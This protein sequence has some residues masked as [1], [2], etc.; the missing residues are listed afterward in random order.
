MPHL[1]I[2]GNTGSGKSVFINDLLI[3]LLL[4]YKPH[5][6]KLILI[7]PKWVELAIYNDIPHLI[8]PVI[9]EANKTPAALQVVILEM[10]RRYQLFAKNGNRDIESYNKKISQEI[11]KLP[12]YIIVID[13]LADL[14][15]Q[16]SKQV[17]EGIM[18]I[19]QMGRAAGIHLVI[20]TQRPSVD[21]ITGVIKNNTDFSPHV[22]VEGIMKL[23]EFNNAF[24]TEQQCLAYIA[25]LKENKCI[26]C[27]N[28]NLNT[29]DLKRMRCLKCNQTFSILTGTIFSRSQTSL[30]SWF[31]LIFR[32]INTKHG[33]PSTDIAK[34]LGV[35][36]KTAWRMTHKIRTR[37]AKQKPQFIVEGTVQIDEMYLSHMGFKKQGR[38]LVNKTLIVG[39]YQKT[40]NNLIV[41]VLKNA[42]SKNLLQFAKNHISSKCLVYTDSWKGYCDFKSVFTKHETVNHQ[43]GYVSKIGVNT[44]QIESVW[45]HIRRTF[46]THIKVAKHRGFL[47]ICVS[48]FYKVTNLD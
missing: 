34:E 15:V 25:N 20:A 41:K 23:N 38:S 14:M 40:T 18:R 16:A 22:L 7:D 1:L 29:S 13:E 21:V 46:K 35:T 47:I 42:K 2:A 32:W 26:R 24:Q 17:E 48:L 12:Y 37:I 36:L 27:F 31:Y 5:E 9:N 33:I 19:T 8:I 6:I 30:T 10:M 3:S 28:F 4:Q 39:I 43:D 11:D 44:N 45:K